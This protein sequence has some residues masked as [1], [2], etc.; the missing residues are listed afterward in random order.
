[1][2]LGG[3]EKLRGCSPIDFGKWLGKP[4]IAIQFGKKWFVLNQNYKLWDCK[5]DCSR[6]ECTEVDRPTKK[7]WQWP[8]SL[9]LLFF[10]L[11]KNM[12]TKYTNPHVDTCPKQQP[13][14][15]AWIFF[16]SQA[17]FT[18]SWGDIFWQISIETP[19]WLWRKKK[20]KNLAWK[21]KWSIFPW[22]FSCGV[23]ITQ[24]SIHSVQNWGRS[25]KAEIQAIWRLG[26]FFSWSPLATTEA[27]RPGLIDIGQ[28]GTPWWIGR[29][30]P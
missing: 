30:R 26:L 11:A 3:L 5:L 27:T 25:L 24:K 13:L 15:M 21:S 28:T 9:K 22:A 12:P 18:E 2:I 14:D 6:D 29:I 23:E 20:G 10:S 1:M 16:R 4:V 19:G 8:L 17:P 7:K